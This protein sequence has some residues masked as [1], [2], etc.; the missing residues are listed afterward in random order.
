MTNIW[1]YIVAALIG[2]ACFIGAWAGLL[3]A[4]PAEIVGAVLIYPLVVICALASSRGG[5]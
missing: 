4:F 5:Y 1:P 2:A 3:P